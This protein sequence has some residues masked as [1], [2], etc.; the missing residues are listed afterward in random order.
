MRNV[1]IG[2]LG[3]QLDM[4][5]RREWRPSVQLCEHPDFP[6]DRLELIHDQRHYHLACNVAK[7]I[8]K[9]SPDTEVR[10]VSIDMANPWDFQEVYG[11]LYDFAAEYGFDEDRERYHVHLTT[12]THVA[13]ICWFLLTESRH[14][15]ARLLQTGPPREGAAPQ[16]TLD[17]IDLD[18][19]RYNALQRRFEAA[20]RDHS[21][22][23]L[24]GIETTSPAMQA[25][26][27]RLDL[28]ATGSDAP[29]LLLGDPGTGKSHLAAQIHELKLVRRR[30][31]GRL[32]QVNCA[33]L[34]GGQALP[35]LFGQRRAATGVAGSERPG[36]LRE[37]D[38]GVLFLDHIDELGLDEQAAL[39]QVIETGRYC[40]VGSEAEVTA[41]FHL[42]ATA[43]S[44]PGALVRAGRLRPDL[45]ARLSQWVVRLP[46][47]RER[48][49]DIQAHLLD[50]IDS[51]ERQ[52]DR[53]TGFNA[54]AL[55][56]Y[57]RFAQDPGTLWPGNLRDLHASAHRMAVLAERG[58]I[59]VPMVE[60]EIA[61]LI[62]QWNSA[63]ADL[64]EVLLAE[65]LPDSARLDEFDRAQL[66]A[67][68]RACRECAN[69]SAA[70]RRLF[71]MSR[72]EKASQ[73]DADRLRKYLSRFGLDW[74][75]VSGN[76][77]G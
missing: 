64:D 39:L 34:R 77:P 76:Q 57:L 6:V 35:A 60:A 50:M 63:T 66:A 74:A 19:T 69:L 45:H 46:P 31:K 28:V 5:K 38:G 29:I 30:I 73:N 25:L 41:R 49:Q 8:A 75:A 17:V 52:L 12:G 62:E 27:A 2:F 51:S 4:G 33:T 67:V 3:T 70:G 56:R 68:I 16:G 54:D 53:K 43:A 22:M 47:L 55:V 7:A 21:A 32:V 9:T 58:R 37:A 48:R 24:G 61:T 36:F 42:I 65:V 59:T 72:A 18:L 23:L 13:Q 11:K 15:P 14:I 71:A 40:P 1:V 20:A 26:A 10:L 44:A